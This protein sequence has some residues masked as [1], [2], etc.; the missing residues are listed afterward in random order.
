MQIDTA[1]DR[2]LVR[3]ADRQHGVVSRQQVLA[4]GLTA[5]Q[6]EQRLRTGLLG[7]LHRGVYA[8]GHRQL[9]REGEWLAAVLAAGPGAALSHRSAAA[10]H[11]LLPERGRR[12]EVVSTARRVRTNWVEAHA[13]RSL[14]PDDVTR[15]GAIPVTTVT[16]TLVDLAGVVAPADLE[17]AVN[18]A[19]VLRLL[20]PA[21]V[22]AALERVRGRRGDGHA[23][24]TAA[25]ARH[26]GPVVLRSA[27]ERRFRALLA[28]HAMPAAEHNVRVA[29]WEVDA[30]W[31]AERLAVELDGARFHDTAAARARD[32]AKDAALEEAGWRLLRLRARHLRGATVA[33]TVAEL[34]AALA[35]GA[36]E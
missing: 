7:R 4:A 25:L 14:G 29:G 30:L 3:L 13:A 34:R 1:P 18:E 32:A 36:R 17:R 33:A 35:A 16:R 23:A 27:L 15:C 21:A 10:L 5:K 24:L 26:H 31:R 11:G 20:D 8:V 2:V 28:A 9:R 19:D 22:A 6:V 12:V